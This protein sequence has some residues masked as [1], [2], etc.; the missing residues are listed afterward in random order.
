MV[1]SYKNHMESDFFPDSLLLPQRKIKANER[2]YYYDCGFSLLQSLKDVNA[3]LNFDSAQKEAQ[4]NTL[5][6]IG[7]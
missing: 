5:R 2:C 6:K 1:F 4:K 7:G 3:S